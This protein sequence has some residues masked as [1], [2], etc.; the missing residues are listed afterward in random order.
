MAYAFRKIKVIVGRV[1]G[2]NAAHRTI[3]PLP[4]P[5]LGKRQLAD[6]Y[7]PHL[8]IRVLC[9]VLN[10]TPEENNSI[11]DS[12]SAMTI[13]DDYPLTFTT[14]RIIEAFIR[15]E[16]KHPSMLKFDLV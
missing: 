9:A 10:P 2:S 1:D 16:M 5:R 14:Q 13:Q 15:V 3:L 6:F 8:W 12:I 4:V 7:E 11:W